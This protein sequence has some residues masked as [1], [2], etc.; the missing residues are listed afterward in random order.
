MDLPAPVEPMIA[1]VC[2]G[3][4][5]QVDAAQHRL[6][7]AGVGEGDVLEDEGAALGDL[8][9]RAR[10]AATTLRLGVEHLDDPV[11]ADRGA[12][13]HHHHEG[14]HH[15]A[16]HDLHEVG[17]VRRQ[18]ADLHRPRTR[19]GARRTTARAT[20]ATLATSITT[21]NIAGLPAAG[22]DARPR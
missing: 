15:H 1:I 10:P 3:S 9:D 2:P 21:G 20:E 12:R 8:G 11:G 14:R 17:E 7:G 22:P 19:P 16:H 18:R 13:D 6:L 4:R 5:L